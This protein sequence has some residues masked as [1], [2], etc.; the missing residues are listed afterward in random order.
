MELQ[1]PYVMRCRA[2]IACLAVVSVS[3]VTYAQD[4]QQ[5]LSGSGHPLTL[6]PDGLASNF[7]AVQIKS[8]IANSNGF[9]DMLMSPMMMLMGALGGMGGNDKDAPPVALLTAMDVSWT[10]GELIMFFGQSYL[11]VYKLDFDMAKMAS[12]P[13]DLSDLNLRLQFVRTDT[14]A[15]FSPRPDITPAEFMKMLK[16]PLP[17]PSEPGKPG[18]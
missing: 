18:Q 11:V 16:T 13:K 15:S 12:T 7:K 5:M 10:T 1:R 6:K 2:L 17:K 14:I 4:A 3:C 9:M 8:T